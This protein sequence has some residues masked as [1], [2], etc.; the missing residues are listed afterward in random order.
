MGSRSSAKASSSHKTNRESSLQ[1]CNGERLEIPSS[2]ICSY[3]API[4]EL[5]RV[6]S[7]TSD[8]LPMTRFMDSSSS[9]V[10]F[11]AFCGAVTGTAASGGCKC[12]RSSQQITDLLALEIEAVIASSEDVDSSLAIQP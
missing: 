6:C 12:V 7:T 3:H 5:Q 8:A 10:P 4:L 2:S 11:G 1:G 9:N